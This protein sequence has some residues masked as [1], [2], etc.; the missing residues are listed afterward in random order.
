[1]F[2]IISW[3]W[4]VKVVAD[5]KMIR[6][7]VMTWTFRLPSALRKVDDSG[8]PNKVDASAC[9][10]SSGVRGPIPTPFWILS[11][12]TRNSAKKIGACSRIGR[13]EANGLVPVSLYS[14][15]VS[16]VMA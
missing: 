6:M 11:L 12:S 9:L 1:M 2:F 15:M 10:A 16:C 4:V 3:R 8:A 5:I 14:A 7:T 13:H